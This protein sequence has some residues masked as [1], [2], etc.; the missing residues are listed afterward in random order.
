[1]TM[2]DRLKSTGFTL[3]EVIVTLVVVSIVGTM[4]FSILGTSMT[5]SSEPLFREKKT[6]NLQQVMENIITAY[7]KYYAGDL[8]GLKDSI[9]TEGTSY[10]NAYGQYT[11][12]DNHY[13]KFVSN[14]EDDELA[15][16]D[17][18]NLLKVTVKNSNNETLTYI[19]AG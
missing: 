7:D 8:P 3:V 16:T 6:F 19:F 17:T 10:N 13:I 12:V 15:E 9:G 11:V 5:K 18:L 2:L 4:I 1:M 14:Q